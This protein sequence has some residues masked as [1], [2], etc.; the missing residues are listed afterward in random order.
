MHCAN[1]SQFCKPEIR[2][3]LCEKSD[4]KTKEA[5]D[6]FFHIVTLRSLAYVTREK[7]FHWKIQ[8]IFNCQER[9]TS[10]TLTGT[11]YIVGLG[12]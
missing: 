10:V 9:K 11:M 2:G 12:Q 6:I 3:H 4:N 8:L 5:A 7:S 1:V